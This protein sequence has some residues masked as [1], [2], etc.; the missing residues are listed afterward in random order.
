MKIN[1]S[2]SPGIMNLTVDF[3]PDDLPELQEV[4]EDQ[5]SPGIFQ[6]GAGVS[7]QELSCSPS[8]NWLAELANI[9]TNP[10]T[11]LLKS[12]PLK[13]F[14]LR[15]NSMKIKS[16]MSVFRDINTEKCTIPV[17]HNYT[18]SPGGCST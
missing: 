12:A 5:R 1:V 9:A 14:V 18:A 13:R 3:S 8:T 6:V 10:K 17:Q 16:L 4:E 11:S 15:Q 7:H 2:H